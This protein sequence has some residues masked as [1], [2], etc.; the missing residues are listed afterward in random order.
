MKAPERINPLLFTSDFSVGDIVKNYRHVLTLHSR[1]QEGYN[2]EPYIDTVLIVR[3]VLENPYFLRR[4]GSKDK[5]TTRGYYAIGKH[6]DD[7]IDFDVYISY[8]AQDSRHFPTQNLLFMVGR[9]ALRLNY[10]GFII[11]KIESS[12]FSLEEWLSK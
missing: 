7:R 5:Y 6:V 4:D 1:V 3:D 2:P 9:F 8:P 10:V 11:E 12:E